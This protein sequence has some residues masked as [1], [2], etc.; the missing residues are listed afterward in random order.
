MSGDSKRVGI[1]NI[2]TDSINARKKKPETIPTRIDVIN[3]QEWMNK[4]R[5]I[6][7]NRVSE[8][9]VDWISS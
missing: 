9:S 8:M 7:A 6:S 2:K 1:H 5:Y 4:K 3:F